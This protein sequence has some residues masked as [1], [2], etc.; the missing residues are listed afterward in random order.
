MVL[1]LLPPESKGIGC[2]SIW[3]SAKI[4]NYLAAFGEENS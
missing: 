3:T 2:G 1:I 4:Q